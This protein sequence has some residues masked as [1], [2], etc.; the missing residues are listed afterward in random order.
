MWYTPVSGIWQTVWLESVCANAIEALEITTGADWAEISTG[1]S[2]HSGMLTLEDGGAYPMENGRVRIQLKN[3]RLWSPEDPKLYCFSICCGA[4]RVQSYFALRTLEIRNVD[5]MPRLCLNG[6][7]YFFHGLLDQGYFSDGIFIPASPEGYARDVRE[8]KRLGF[9]TLRKHIKVESQRFYYECDRQG[10][11]VFQDM[12]N[13]GHYNFIRDT[14]LPT[15]GMKSLPDRLLHTDPETR[16]N[17]LAGMDKTVAQ[18][19]NHP[20]ICCWVIFN[21][22]WGQFDSTAA[23]RRLK[24]MDDSRFI[25]GSSGWFRGGESD[26]RSHHCYFKPFRFKPHAKPVLLTE[27]GGYSCKLAEHSFNPDNT[28]GYRFFKT[29]TELRAALERLYREEIIPAV[30]RGLCAAILTQLSDVE[31]ETNGMLSYDRKVCKA[32]AQTMLSIADRLRL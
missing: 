32:D 19:R 29:Q 5:G 31:D 14:A 11:I 1:N 20:C 24:G 9:N 15:V 22:G 17:F 13:N 16:A 23:Y 7:P 6:K 26:V 4:D 18:L 25:I 10:M 3:P 30:P 21:E 2:T 12:V 28:Y 8:A 27:F